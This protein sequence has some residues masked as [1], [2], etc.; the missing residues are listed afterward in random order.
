[1][2]RAGIRDPF[3]AWGQCAIESFDLARKKGY[4]LIRVYG[5][6][7]PGREHWA[8]FTSAD[9]DEETGQETYRVVD[10]TARQFSTKV[11]ARYE[12]DMDTWLDDAC[13]WLGDSLHYEWFSQVDN[14]QE[15][16]YK[17]VWIR[18]DIDPDTYETEDAWRL[19]MRERRGLAV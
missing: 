3:E 13:E 9:Y 14:W 2:K 12:T 16:I 7:Y 4:G 6:T 10:L 8:C 5:V 17:D 1:M 18:E 19:A 11:P 15:P